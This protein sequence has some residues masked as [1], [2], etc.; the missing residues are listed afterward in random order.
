MKLDLMNFLIKIVISSYGLIFVWMAQGYVQSK[1]NL[2]MEVIAREYFENLA[3]RSFFQ[4][5]EK[6][7]NNGNIRRC[8]MH[9]IVH[10]LHN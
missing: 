5:F 9:D 6:D 4:D 8:K 1:A 10:I 2:E 7:V 3:I